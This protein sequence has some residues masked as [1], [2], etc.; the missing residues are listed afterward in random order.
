MLSE[1]SCTWHLFNDDKVT[2]SVHMFLNWSWTIRWNWNLRFIG[3]SWTYLHQIFFCLCFILF[4]KW[5]VF[6]FCQEL[7]NTSETPMWTRVSRAFVP[8]VSCDPLALMP[9]VVYA[10]CALMLYVPRVLNALVSHLS[11]ALRNLCHA[12]LVLCLFPCSTYLLT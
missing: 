8:N 9:Y 3:R 4:V 5:T 6:Q 7:H 10:L 2:K 12:S 11:H 1:K